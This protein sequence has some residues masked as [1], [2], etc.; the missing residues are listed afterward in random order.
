MDGDWIMF[1][2]MMDFQHVNGI[3]QVDAPLSTIVLHM[4]N[5]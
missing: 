4:V 2:E 3:T 5:S 1:G